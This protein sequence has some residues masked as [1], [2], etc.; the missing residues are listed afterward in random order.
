MF[1]RKYIILWFLGFVLFLG[2]GAEA[3]AG[4]NRVFKKCLIIGNSI[5]EHG[6]LKLKS[7]GWNGNWGMAASSKEK[8][9]V[10]QLYKRICEAQPG[11]TPQLLVRPMGRI[12][13]ALKFLDK[14]VAI[15][16]DLIII[17]LGENEGGGEVTK[18][19]FGAKY[20]RLV[21][22][23]KEQG[24][25]LII[26][27]GVWNP[28][29]IEPIGAVIPK[30]SKNSLIKEVCEKYECVFVDIGCVS[31]RE[32]NV[33]RSEGRYK[34]WGVAW[35]PGD[36]G[37]KGYCEEIWAAL[38]PYMMRIPIKPML[39]LT[40]IVPEPQ[41]VYA[42]TDF[43]KPFEITP[44]TTIVLREDASKLQGKAAFL[45]K[46]DI[47]K[48]YGYDVPVVRK[49][50]SGQKSALLLVND[51]KEITTLWEDR[52]PIVK[53]LSLKGHESYQLTSDK[54]IVVIESIASAGLF[55]G[56]QTLRQMLRG[57]KTV[58]AVVISDWPDQALR[59]VYGGE[60]DMEHFELLICKMARLKINMLVTE[61]PWNAG[62]NWWYNPNG[63]KGKNIEYSRLFFKLCRE[64][65]VEPVPLVQGLGWGYG[66]VH[67][68]PNCSEGLWV[69]DEEY[70]LKG[71]TP[72]KIRNPNVIRTE[73]API[74]VTDKKKKIVYQENSDY[75]IIP[76][77]TYSPFPKTHKPWKIT[78]V[79]GGKI[80]DG[81][82]VLIS[83]NYMT[84]GAHAAYC[85]SEPMTYKIVDS[86]LTWT[87]Q[88]LSPRYIHI[89]HDEVGS[90]KRCSR[91]IQSGK[92]AA[93]LM[94][95]D[96][97]HWYNMIKKLDPNITVMM[98]DDL[99]RK[100]KCDG[101]I[102]S[103]VPEDV[104]ICPW[105]YWTTEKERKEMA[106]RMSWF[107]GQND[108]K[109]LG[110]CSGYRHLNIWQW[111]D[112]VKKYDKH[113]GNLGFMYS[114]WGE[115]STLWSAASFSAEYMWSRSKP[116]K[117][118]FDLYAVADTILRDNGLSATTS[119]ERQ[120]PGLNKLINQMTLQA[121]KTKL[122]S[123]KLSLEVNIRASQIMPYIWPE[124]ARTDVA[125]GTVPERALTQMTR[126]PLYL[127]SASYFI[128]AIGAHNSGNT[129]K[130]EGSLIKAC[131]LFNRWRFPGYDKFDNL[132]E[133][134]KKSRKFPSSE[135]VFGV[136]LRCPSVMEGDGIILPIAEFKEMKISESK[137][138]RI[139][140]LGSI[141]PVCRID[142]ESDKTVKASVY[143]SRDG[144]NYRQIKEATETP[145]ISWPV[146]RARFLKLIWQE[147]SGQ[148]IDKVVLYIKRSPAKYSC[149]K[150]TGD[151]WQEDS[152]WQ[153]ISL[154]DMFVSCKWEVSNCPTYAQAVYDDHNL[155]VRFVC[156]FPIGTELYAEGYP[157][158]D[159]D[160]V[161]LF[162]KPDRESNTYYQVII[163]S[164]QKV[165]T[166]VHNGDKK[167][168]KVDVICHTEN[169]RWTCTMAIPLQWFNKT[170]ISL[171]K[172]WGVNFCR[173]QIKPSY[174]L[175]S[176]AIMPEAPFWFLQPQNFGT[177]SFLKPISGYNENHK[178]RKIGKL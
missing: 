166:L 4:H 118:V 62:G 120:R 24:N 144:R 52:L 17:Q 134:Y 79:E 43:H 116:E 156:T 160:C 78:R 178:C 57:D 3:S 16:A 13:N 10:H 35:H 138:E 2:K 9:F 26:C 39:K 106:Y 6:P 114:H 41:R 80:P 145:T 31:Y 73:S 172:T 59:V 115:S 128:E 159:D 108:R 157:V 30:M 176:W 173:T 89:G 72:V 56:A 19:N 143:L 94:G 77:R 68:N 49:K 37:M 151:K 107:L 81:G 32:K 136:K 1:L 158:W 174:N 63:K 167:P 126:I 61:S 102:L 47:K 163:N 69:P 105:I 169:N 92:S 18:D 66:V 123:T 82:E 103:F 147:D 93:E 48:L 27:T 50:L 141:Y 150:K 11:H 20:G 170:D 74:I 168:V 148:K 135:D 104:I 97:Q 124:L 8:D 28:D 110:T 46:E 139:Y 177:L 95:G 132:V 155:Y 38:R 101:K 153:N 127:L 84:Y 7:K 119:I 98:W 117:K 121:T 15:K 133:E 12:N 171:K 154:A 51:V 109:V 87:V 91:C 64:Y 161:Q 129:V 54:N 162:L 88:N 96:I 99:L 131:E 142:I 75:L 45:L 125:T 65:N 175:S 164:A 100:N 22:A 85:P 146:E 33:A 137:G 34:Y 67:Q 60:S 149:V 113:P 165:C 23:L 71:I 111:R 140:D 42:Y 53:E 36:G 70:V 86:T 25:P 122:V 55:Y 29:Q 83:Y 14:L 90:M 76:G 21:K 44:S 112:A 152:F 58:P 40:G 5:T 130:A